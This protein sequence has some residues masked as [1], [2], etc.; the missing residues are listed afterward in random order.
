M[1]RG[2]SISDCIKRTGFSSP[3]GTEWKDP[4]LFLLSNLSGTGQ[5]RMIDCVCVVH[6]CFSDVYLFLNVLKKGTMRLDPAAHRTW[7]IF[8]PRRVVHACVQVCTCVW[9]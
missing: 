2:V 5:Y 3:S 1:F 7:F 6:K 8:F 4:I 9:Q